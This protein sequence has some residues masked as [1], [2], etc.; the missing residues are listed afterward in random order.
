VENMMNRLSDLSGKETG[1]IRATSVPTNPRTP[2]SRTHTRIHAISL[3]DNTT[4]HPPQS[5]KLRTSS[6]KN[7][8]RT[9]NQLSPPTIHALP[10]AFT[11][12]DSSA[13]P[14]TTHTRPRARR[15]P[16]NNN[17]HR[18]RDLPCNRLV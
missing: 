8:H 16:G 14:P 7:C 18:L 17:N 15:L 4:A 3:P 11:L 5:D 13:I 2:D 1:K 10:R 12:A 6:D 9:R